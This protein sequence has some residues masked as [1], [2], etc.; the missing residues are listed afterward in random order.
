MKVPEQSVCSRHELGSMPSA[1]RTVRLL[2]CYTLRVISP[3]IDCYHI[4]T[5]TI[6]STLWLCS[7]YDLS[8]RTGSLSSN[9]CCAEQSMPRRSLTACQ[10][11]SGLRPEDACKASCVSVLPWASTTTLT[12]SV[13]KLSALNKKPVLIDYC[14]NAFARCF[15]QLTSV[16]QGAI[17]IEHN[18]L[19]IGHRPVSLCLS[20]KGV[21]QFCVTRSHRGIV[22]SFMRSA[23][24]AGKANEALRRP[25]LTRSTSQ[26]ESCDVRFHDSSRAR[27]LQI[28]VILSQLSAAWRKLASCGTEL[29]RSLGSSVSSIKRTNTTGLCCSNQ[30]C[31]RVSL[32]SV[33][34]AKARVFRYNIHTLPSTP[35][36]HDDSTSICTIVDALVCLDLRVHRCWSSSFSDRT[37]TAFVHIK[38]H[39][40]LFCRALIYVPVSQLVTV[41]Q[42]IDTACGA[43]NRSSLQA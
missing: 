1:P 27:A 37:S 13:T 16:Q 28:L 20:R 12:T 6:K 5:A 35:M 23:T 10:A 40:Q 4:Q 30:A 15:R 34:P 32:I 21:L 18:A 14:N 31:S 7:A 17:Q 11:S 24:P 43:G 2:Y 38:G 25:L 42:M 26:A 39:A 8:D 22:W 9:S 19:H 41:L 29:W 36:Q 3:G 33:R